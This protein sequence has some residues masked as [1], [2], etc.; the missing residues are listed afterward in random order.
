MRGKLNPEKKS[1][2][3]SIKLTEYMEKKLQHFKDLEKIESKKYAGEDLEKLKNAVA[4]KYHNINNK[5]TRLLDGTILP[6]MANLIVFFEYLTKYPQLRELFEDDVKELFGYV[7]GDQK[8]FQE[9]PAIIR[10]FISAV[11]N[12]WPLIKKDP[13]DPNSEYVQDPN[14]FRLDVIGDLQTELMNIITGL[15]REDF[16]GTFGVNE[17]VNTDMGRAVTWAKLYAQRYT[18]SKEA[19]EDYKTKPSRPVSF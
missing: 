14:N 4:K 17:I 9:R 18:K 2:R 19:E 10:R 13:K 15:A 11:F 5:K 1:Y 6:S 7:R 8:K 12:S 3:S 16:G